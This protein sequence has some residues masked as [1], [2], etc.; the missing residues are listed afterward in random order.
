[1]S[2]VSL[3]NEPEQSEEEFCCDMGARFSTGVNGARL[4]HEIPADVV[5]YI[6]DWRP[7]VV[8]EKNPRTPDDKAIPSLLIGESEKVVLLAH[9]C[10]WC[11]RNVAQENRDRYFKSKYN[12][13]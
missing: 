1:M 9:F 2:A 5:D 12:K 8:G 13:G 7:L 4:S 10:C 6:V 11:G 3:S